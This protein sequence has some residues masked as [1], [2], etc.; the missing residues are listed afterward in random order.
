MRSPPQPRESEPARASD[1]GAGL[2]L[3][4]AQAAGQG[5]RCKVKLVDIVVDEVEE[6]AH[7]LVGR[8]LGR[9]AGAPQGGVEAC[10]PL[11]AAA[12]GLVA[13][14]QRVRQPR[15]VLGD[16]LQFLQARRVGLEQR[17]RQRLRQ[18]REQPVVL[19]DRELR[20][21]EPELV[22]ERQQ[23][24][25]GDRALVV[26][27]L[28]Q[29]AGGNADALGELALRRAARQPEIADLAA[30]EEFA[31]RHGPPDLQIRIFNFAFLYCHIC[32]C[33]TVLKWQISA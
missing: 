14:D 30:D 32:T 8:R 11:A 27:D 10:E 3:R 31:D 12:V 28:V 9:A 13:G 6:V 33:S 5:L 23:H 15:R 22:G 4:D 26:L 25:C 19:A 16:E 18:R 20:D 17:V 1:G 29:I 24:R 21:V 2:G 7:L